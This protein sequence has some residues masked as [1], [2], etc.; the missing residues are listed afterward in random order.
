MKKIIYLLLL[1][2]CVISRNNTVNASNDIS[3]TLTNEYGDSYTVKVIEMSDVQIM[4]NSEEGFSQTV[5]IDLTPENLIANNSNTRS[6]WD[7]TSSVRAT[8]TVSWGFKNSGGITLVKVN[9]VSGGY[10]ISQ[11][12]VQVTSASLNV[13]TSGWSD[14]SANGNSPK[15]YNVSSSFSVNPGFTHYV[16]TS[17]YSGANITLGINRGGTS[18][19][20]YLQNN[21]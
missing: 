6:A 19:T 10:T 5:V 18:W 20:L 4:T 15:Y 14:T 11:S 13:G 16:T 3:A 12:G 1:I 17:G 21:Y 7:S 2:F 8:L 9:S